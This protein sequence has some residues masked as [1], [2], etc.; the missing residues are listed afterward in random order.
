VLSEKNCEEIDSFQSFLFAKSSDWLII[1]V[2]SILIDR[3]PPEGQGQKPFRQ[4]AI[5]EKHNQCL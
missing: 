2:I 5:Y 3:S 1:E 4:G